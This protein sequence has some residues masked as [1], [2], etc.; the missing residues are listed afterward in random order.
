MDGA[1]LPPSLILAVHQPLYGTNSP[2]F[3]LVFLGRQSGDWAVPDGV[4]MA[5]NPAL[6]PQ[7]LIRRALHLAGAKASMIGLAY[8]LFGPWGAPTTARRGSAAG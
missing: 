3:P 6:A 8:R 2:P 4:P 5:G 7:T 1:F